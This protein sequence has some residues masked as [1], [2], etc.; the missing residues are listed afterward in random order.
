M[1]QFFDAAED[2]RMTGSFL[3]DS[4][5]TTEDILLLDKFLCSCTRV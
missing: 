3:K 2:D 4:V 5:C 1:I